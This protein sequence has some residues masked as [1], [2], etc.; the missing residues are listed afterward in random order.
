ME[1]KRRVLL[2]A[3]HPM[4]ASMM[5]FGNISDSGALEKT[6]ETSGYVLEDPC[7][8]IHT[9]TRDD[10]NKQISCSSSLVDK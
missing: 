2:D 7:N 9:R 4:P 3:E 6:M 1:T 10:G 8:D 5:H